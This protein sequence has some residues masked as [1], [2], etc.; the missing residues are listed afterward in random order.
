VIDIDA[1]NI[2]I[3][4][5]YVLQV[6]MQEMIGDRLTSD[7]RDKHDLFSSLIHA[8]KED[9]EGVSL[10]EEELMGSCALATFFYLKAQK[11]SRE[12]LR[13]FGGWT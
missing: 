10:T 11:T 6:Y 13:V 8:N 2:E 3:N 12:Y 5:R 9:L 7:I 4:D 1:Q